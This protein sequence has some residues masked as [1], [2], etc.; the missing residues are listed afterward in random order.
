MPPEIYILL[1]AKSEH[2]GAATNALRARFVKA[3]LTDSSLHGIVG[4]NGDFRYEG[5]ATAN[6]VAQHGRRVGRLLLLRAQAGQVV[7]RQQCNGA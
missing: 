5:C 2:L 3:L 4:S 7:K 6:T 1:G